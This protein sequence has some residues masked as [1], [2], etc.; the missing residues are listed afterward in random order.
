VIV[1]EHT[2]DF[3]RDGCTVGAR[4]VEYKHLEK[5]FVCAVC[6][7]NPVHHM[8][9]ENGQWADW[10]ECADCES[11]DFISQRR[12]DQQCREYWEILEGL[13]PDLRALFP[14]RERYKGT[15]DEAISELFDL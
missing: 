14:E 9:Q 15:A 8:R 12:Y 3:D 6:G 11:R 10:A 1:Y 13:P 2:I 4:R 5:E 7:G